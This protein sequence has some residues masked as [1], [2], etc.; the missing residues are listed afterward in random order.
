M[1]GG[2][3]SHCSLGDAPQRGQVDGTLTHSLLMRELEEARGIPWGLQAA[4]PVWHYWG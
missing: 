2:S 3:S 1:R 4:G